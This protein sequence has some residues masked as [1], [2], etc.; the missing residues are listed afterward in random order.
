MRALASILALVLFAGCATVQ[1]PASP[2]V[3]YPSMSACQNQH[4]QDTPG[5][6]TKTLHQEATTANTFE[7]E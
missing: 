2:G 1:H 7:V 6:C 4:I 3:Q 5:D